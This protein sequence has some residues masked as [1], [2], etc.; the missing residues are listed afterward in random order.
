M[1]EYKHRVA[2]IGCGVMGQIY[3][4]AYTT[5]PDTAIPNMIGYLES[6]IRK[7]LTTV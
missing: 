4:E 6:R 7:Y 5:Y 2:I 1:S 3:A